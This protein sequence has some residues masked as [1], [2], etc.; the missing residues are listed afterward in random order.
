[1]KTKTLAL[2]LLSLALASCVANNPSDSSSE[3][4]SSGISS[5]IEESSSSGEV[6]LTKKLDSKFYMSPSETGG[7]NEEGAYPLPTSFFDVSPDVPYVSFSSFFTGV[8]NP[9][10]G[11]GKTIISYEGGTLTNEIT[12]ATMVFDAEKNTI[13][14]DD[15]DMFLSTVSNHILHEDLFMTSTNPNAKLD[16]TKSTRV[17]GKKMSWDLNRYYLK[18]VSYEG[19]VYAPYSLLQALF[20]SRV[21]LGIAFNGVNYFNSNF[22]AMFADMASQTLNDYGKAYYGGSLGKEKYPVRSEA[23]SKYFYGTFLFIMETFNG[24]LSSMGIENLDSYLDE[25]GYKEELLSSDA[26]N[27]DSTLASLMNS[28]FCDGGHTAYTGSGVDSGMDMTRDISLMYGLMTQDPRTIASEKVK[29]DLKTKRGEDYKKVE[30]SGSTAIIR[31][32]SFTLNTNE[33]GAPVFPTKETVASDKK[34]TFATLYNGFEEIKKDTNVKNVILDV[35][36]NGGG[37]VCAL[38]EALGFLTNDEVTFTTYNPVTGAK[39]IE[40]AKYDTD[41]DGDF[42]DDDSYQGIY[43]FYIL[44]SPCSF[45]SGNALPCISSDYGYAKIIGQKSG[46]GDCAVCY[47]EG[48]DGSSWQMSSTSSIRHKDGTSVDTG[49]KVDYEID[50]ENFYD[51]AYLDSYINKAKANA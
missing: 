9:L 5:S 6:K 27:A 13:T 37:A 48:S 18:L 3:S 29:T 39:N 11:G 14:C 28:V 25:K 43:D 16:E 49:A 44:T 26:E 1:M 47:A 42:D 22:A 38:G 33:L 7:I 10:V 30:I 8:Y 32:D 40:V 36:L 34:G 21:G 12:N 23:Y 35:S 50:Y 45:S 2:T 15:L 17:A 41:L 51:A 4:S 24:K 46:G 19:E 31:F 20:I